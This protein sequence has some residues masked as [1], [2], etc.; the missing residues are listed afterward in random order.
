MMNFKTPVWA[1]AGHTAIDVTVQ[2]PVYGWIPYTCTA[3][4]DTPEGRELWQ[5]LQSSDIGAYSAPVIPEYALAEQARAKRDQLLS[6]TDYLVQPDYPISAQKL[7]DVK[8][9]R[10]ALRDITQQPDFP[11]II[12]WPERNF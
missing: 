10:Q 12:N 11:R 2:H 3:H 5:A 1:D 4:M 8:A 9:Y 7:A 6:D